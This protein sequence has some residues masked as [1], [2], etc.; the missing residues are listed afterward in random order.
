MK[1]IA[2]KIALAAL[3]LGLVGNAVA[4]DK[5]FNIGLKLLAPIVIS[6]SKAMDFPDTVSGAASTLVTTAAGTDAA[7]LTATGEANRAATAS[8]VE[9]SVEITTGLGDDATKRITV[10]TFTLGGDI[11]VGGAVTFDGT[12]N[13]SDMRVGATAHVESNDIAGDY[14]GTATFRLVYN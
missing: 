3:S 2:S 5:T 4:V 1:N 11:G 12:G 6:E 8:V 9:T 7:I 10:D 13:L 14:A